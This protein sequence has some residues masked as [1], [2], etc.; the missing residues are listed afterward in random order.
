M[1][2]IK[3]VWSS[4][5]SRPEDSF[6][7]LA[8]EGVCVC[9][10]ARA[11]SLSL[12]LCDPMDCTPPCTSVHGISQARILEWVAIPSSRASSQPVSPASPALASGI[13]TTE[14]PGK[15]TFEYSH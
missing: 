1:S 7:K 3:E 9:V 2:H 11:Q 10:C 4:A 12:T 13:F 15:P 6:V 14:L 5:V 8:F